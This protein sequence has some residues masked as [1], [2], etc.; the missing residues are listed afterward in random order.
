MKYYKD[1]AFWNKLRFSLNCPKFS[2]ND[3]TLNT[4]PILGRK[5]GEDY[6]CSSGPSSNFGVRQI[7]STRE[8][9]RAHV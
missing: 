8:I 6:G 9:G 2:F 7:H 4:H 5:S 1:N 3:R